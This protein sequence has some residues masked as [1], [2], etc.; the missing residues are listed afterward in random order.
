MIDDIKVNQK[1]MFCFTV[2]AKSQSWKMCSEDKSILDGWR[3]NLSGFIIVWD[4]KR[5]GIYDAKELKKK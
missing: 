3:N 4:L 1:E 2:D 5:K